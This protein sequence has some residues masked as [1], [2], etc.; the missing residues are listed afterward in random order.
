MVLNIPKSELV[1]NICDDNFY[2]ET[3]LLL[4]VRKPTA[5]FLLGRGRGK[6][7]PVS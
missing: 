1:P 5:K 4:Q 7:K 6:V 3:H 2:Y